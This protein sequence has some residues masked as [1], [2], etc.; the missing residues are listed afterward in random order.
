MRYTTTVQ[1]IIA[2]AASSVEMPCKGGP[3]RGCIQVQKSPA[4]SGGAFSCPTVPVLPSR[5]G[6]LGT[7]AIPKAPSVLSNGCGVRWSL[8]RELRGGLGARVDPRKNVR[9]PPE[10]LARLIIA[11]KPYWLG[12]ATLSAQSRDVLAR[13]GDAQRSQLAKVNQ[14]FFQFLTHRRPL[15]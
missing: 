11:A 5:S 12:K 2:V 15:A 1:V 7:P 3:M 8:R 9:V 13:V 6:S 14:Q 4:G 10:C